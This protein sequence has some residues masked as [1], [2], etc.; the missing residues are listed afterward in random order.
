MTEPTPRTEI[1]LADGKYI[2]L[3]KDGQ[4]EVLRY[5]E[6]WRDLVGDK[7]V[8][9]MADRIEDLERENAKLRQ[10]LAALERKRREDVQM[11]YA[12]CRQV[13]HADKAML[14]IRAAFPEVFK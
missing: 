11:C 1:V 7:F 2:Y 10:Q 5:G 3:R 12:L 9:C 8:F 13:I 14:A 4:Q 6:P